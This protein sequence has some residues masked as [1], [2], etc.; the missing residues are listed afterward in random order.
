[1]RSAGHG[2]PFDGRSRSVYR[3]PGKRFRSFSDSYPAAHL[4]PVLIEA[5]TV[6]LKVKQQMFLWPSYHSPNKQAVAS[7][8]TPCAPPR[9]AAIHRIGA[10]HKFGA[11]QPFPA[12]QSN[13][14]STCSR[15]N[16]Q[17]LRKAPKATKATHVPD[18]AAREWYG[19][20][21]PRIG[22]EP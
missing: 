18:I 4:V 7:A 2:H 12:L 1:M 15:G 3:L 22:F 19:R 8:E 20:I 13:P 10:A 16:A 6:D 9:A 5:R 11:G 21:A 17:K 14:P